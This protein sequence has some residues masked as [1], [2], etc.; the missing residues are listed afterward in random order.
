MSVARL[1][2]AEANIEYYLAIAA[3]ST[4]TAPE[5]ALFSVAFAPDTSTVTDIPSSNL[6]VGTLFMLKVIL[7]PGFVTLN[8]TPP[9]ETRGSK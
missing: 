6:V 9:I 8:V 3:R 7:P 5:T 4:L 1:K 2:V